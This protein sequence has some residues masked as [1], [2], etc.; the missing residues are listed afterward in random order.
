MQL[1]K[2]MI[3]KSSCT[4]I[5][6]GW[7][8]ENED[9]RTKFVEEFL[10]GHL[11]LE[12]RDIKDINHRHPLSGHMS[13]ATHVQMRSS[14]ARTSV[15]KGKHKYKHLLY[16][17]EEDQQGGITIYGAD[18]VYTIQRK[19]PMKIALSVLADLGIEPGPLVKAWGNQ[20]P[21]QSPEWIA[22]ST[23]LPIIEF[24]WSPT[25]LAINTSKEVHERQ[26]EDAYKQKWEDKY[27]FDD[28]DC[29]AWR[30]SVFPKDVNPDEWKDIIEKA[31]DQ[32][33]NPGQKGKGKAK[34]KGQGKGKSKAQVQGKGKGKGKGKAKGSFYPG[35]PGDI[36]YERRGG[37]DVDEEWGKK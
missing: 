19:K 17:T 2:Q 4:L 26:F 3:E 28:L 7:R 5:F 12:G 24:I 34:G 30:M 8:N 33:Q 22:R 1:E 6:R 18:S 13:K 32:K 27:G 31:L 35:G 23:G 14:N 9:Q 20:T 36:E 15:L 11:G 16:Y 21:N 10:R 25:S 29:Y 37:M